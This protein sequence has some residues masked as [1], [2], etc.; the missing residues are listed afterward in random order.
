MRI[1]TPRLLA[2][3]AAAVLPLTSLIAQGPQVRRSEGPLLLTANQGS[4]SATLIE[5]KSGNIVANI[6]VGV[7]PHE[8]AASADG[9]NAIVTVYGLQGPGNM[10]AVIDLE[11]A[12]V[13]RMIDLGVYTRPHGARFLADNRTLLVT[14][15]TRQAVVVV[16]VEAGTVLG[17]IPTGNPGSHMLALPASMQKVYTANM[18]NGTLSE[19]DVASKT[20]LRS[21]PVAT[22]TEGIG[23]TPDG[24]QAWVGSNDGKTVSVVD[25]AQ[26]KVVHTMSGFGFPYRI[27]FSPDGTRAIVSDPMSDELRIYDVKGFTELGR[28]AT[29]QGSAPE[30]VHF[31]PDGK[32]AWITLNGGNAI[33]EID[34]AAKTVARRF[35]TEIRPDGVTYINRP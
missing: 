28:V 17:A 10:L 14:S 2:V 9:K 7:G 15:E 24:A 31:S 29:G 25:I 34:V 12:T 21:M 1:V 35:P 26:W 16:D 33:A 22:R 3:L 6:P 11:T 13:K 23:V 8:V 18:F 20:L 19:M 5:L 27:G 32:L 30:G 4:A